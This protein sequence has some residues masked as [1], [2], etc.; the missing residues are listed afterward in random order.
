MNIPLVQARAIFT[1]T[2]IDSYKERTPATAFLKSFFNVTTTATKT[3]SIEVQRG[4]EK[5]A[6]DVMRGVDGNRNQFS[7]SSEKEFMPLFYNENFDATALDRYDVV[8]GKSENFA[9]ET[10]GYLASDV[11]EKYL[12]LRDKIERAK[13]LQAAQVFDTGIIT[14]KNG[15][16]IDFKRKATSKVDNNANPWTTAAT[17]VEGQLVAAGKFIR[18]KG[19]NASPEFNLIISGTAWIALKKTDYFK[20]NA[21]YNQVTLLDINMPQASSLGA[22]Y[23]GRITAGSFIFNVWTYDEGYEADNGT[24]TPYLNPKNAIVLPVRGHRLIMAHAGVP[25]IIRDTK[26][27]EFNQFIASVA[28]EYY[29][30]NYIDNVGKAHI[31]EIYSA[32]LAVPVT[33]DMIYTTQILPN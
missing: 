14:L 1:K 18:E 33:V 7:R 19:K 20:N 27:A 11:A 2:L 31:F 9:P 28:S 5:I 32:P 16:T 12:M 22:Y 25:A 30:N 24:W 8:F 29:L 23:H 15:T 26:N 17:D 21:N 13:E 3:V 10:I 4:T 6:A